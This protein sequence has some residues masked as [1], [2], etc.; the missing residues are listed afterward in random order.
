MKKL[1]YL[2][3]V[4]GVIL[5][6]GCWEN[7]VAE[8]KISILADSRQ[9]IDSSMTLSLQERAEKNF[10][11]IKAGPADPGKVVGELI[12]G[13]FGAVVGGVVF[14][15]QGFNIGSEGSGS[16]FCCCNEGGI[17]GAL[18]GYLVG[19]NVGSSVGVFLVGNSGGDK[20]SYWASL[21]GSLLGTVMGG[22]VAGAI[23]RNSNDDSGAAPL[24]ILTAAQAGGA[25]I[26]FNATRKKKVKV[27]SGAMLNLKDGKFAFA[28]P[29]VNTSQDAFNSNCYKVNFFKANF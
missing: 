15:R 5:L 25:T 22:L 14:A 24:F 18:I 3:V 29:Q 23:L 4:F 1:T 6:T 26:S 21:G 16:C 20:G 9:S 13:G 27:P 2:L 12:A 19:S 17:I 8:E 10:A 28:F 7:S 11:Y